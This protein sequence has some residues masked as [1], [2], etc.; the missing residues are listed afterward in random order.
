MNH[1]SKIFFI[2]IATIFFSINSYANFSS[3]KNYFLKMEFDLNRCN[4]F[5][6]KY[7]SYPLLKTDIYSSLENFQPESTECINI[8]DHYL[9]EI[10]NFNLNSKSFIG[11]S[12][13]DS[14]SLNLNDIRSKTYDHSNIYYHHSNSINNFQ[15]MI[16]VFKN[17]NSIFYDNSYITYYKNNNSFTLG[18][19]NLWWG[20]SEVTSLILSNQAQGIPMVLIQNNRP[21]DAGFIKSLNY[22]FFVGKLEEKRE[23]PNA[24]IMGLRLESRFKNLVLGLSRTAQFGGDGRPS[25]FSTIKDIIIGNDNTGNKD[26]DPSNQLAAIDFEYKFIKNHVKFYGQLAGEDESGYLPS[27][28]FYNIGLNKNLPQHNRK[29]T[30]DYADTFSSS[31]I[32]NYTYNHFIYKDGYRYKDKPIG[33]SID[34]D[35]RLLTIAFD[36]RLTNNQ[37]F[38]YK[39]FTG[40]INQNNSV[41]NYISPKNF[42]LKGMSIELNKKIS[43]RLDLYI[44]ANFYDEV[45]EFVKNNFILNLE[46]QL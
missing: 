20:P 27:R 35:S 2:F 40:T 16:S 18:K 7:S 46:Y 25:G 19:I 12:Y 42:K 17:N 4:F 45:N 31:S 38:R 29:I 9:T 33:A 26:K 34:A 24:R 41:K 39:I 6:P 23:I 28:T 22:K 37:N 30:L 15:Y 8:K 1:I 32:E 43:S 13:V 11:L 36:K 44:K 14:E 10:R 5:I 21:F 3:Y